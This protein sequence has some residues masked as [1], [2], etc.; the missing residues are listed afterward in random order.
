MVPR[1]AEIRECSGGD[2]AHW[3]FQSR[4]LWSGVHTHSSLFQVSERASSRVLKGCV[5]LEDGLCRELICPRVDQMPGHHLQLSQ[6]ASGPWL[7]TNM[8]LAMAWPCI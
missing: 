1:A 7:N 2:L 4:S 8:C 3:H 6:M 5:S